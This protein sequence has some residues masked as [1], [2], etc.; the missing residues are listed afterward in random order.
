MGHLIW[1]A[2]VEEL[3][4]HTRR[5]PAGNHCPSSYSSSFFRVLNTPWPCSSSD[6]IPLLVFLLLSTEYCVCIHHMYCYAIVAVLIY[7]SP[8]Y[9]VNLILSVRPVSPMYTAPHSH[10]ILY[11]SPLTSIGSCL[12]FTL[13]SLFL[14]VVCVL[15]IVMM[16]RCA[17]LS[18]FS[19]RP[20]MC[21][22]HSVLASFLPVCLLCLFSFLGSVFCVLP[23]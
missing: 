3:F 19:L 20:L 13:T 15:C 1:G 16:L 17:R 14:I 4:C 22:I 9:S 7:D 23:T 21:G 2:R 11:I 6:K 5:C 12:P 18:T 8:R 10:G